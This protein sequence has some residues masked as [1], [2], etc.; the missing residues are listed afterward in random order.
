[1]KLRYDRPARSWNEALPIGNGRLGAMVF[2]GVE[3]EHLQ[4]NEDTLWSGTPKD[5]NNPKAKEMLAEVRKLIVDEK[6]VEADRVCRGMMGPYTQSYLP[7]GDLH[8]QFYH[9]DTFHS[10]ERSLNLQS[11]TVH[12]DY[13]V[14]NVHYTREMFA[15]FPD[16]A[17][18]IR[19]TASKPGFLHFSVNLGS[20]LKFTTAPDQDQFVLSGICP[21][22]VDPSYYHSDDPIQYGDPDKTEAIKFEGRIGV[23]AEDGCMHVDQDGLHVTEAT[24]V[25]LHFS[26]ATSFNGYDK[27]PGL[28][29][30][31]P[32]LAAKAFLERAMA[33]SFEELKHS[34]MEDY[35]SFFNRVE[36][37]LGPSI[38]PE[39]LPTDQ[40]ILDYGAKDPK[41]VELLFQYGR[42]LMI[43]SS[44]PGSQPANLQGIWNR[45]VR[46]PWSSNYTLNIN[47]QMNYWPVE[48]CN[49]SE[50]HEPL[51]N[52]IEELAQNG[53]KTASINYGCSG[54]TAHHNADIWR[55]SGPVGDYGHGDPVWAFWPLGGVWLS[56][57]LWE[58]F[59]FAKNQAYLRETAY[60]IMKEAA[61]FCLDWLID[62]GKG[63]LVTAPSTS[64]EHKFMTTD[65]QLAA[66]SMATTMDMSLIWELFTNCI[67]AAEVL[68]I[69]D[70]FRH[71]L[72]AAR[73][74]LYPMQIGRYGQ[75]QEWIHDFEDEDPH[76]RHVSHLFGVF[77]GRQLTD[78]EGRELFDAARR[79]LER[80][81]DHGTG[82]SLAWKIC[83]WARFK[84]GDRAHRL[85]S[86][87]L[88][89]VN[90][91][92][93]QSQ[94]GGV[95][96]NLFD[97]HP[98]F[99]IDGNFG[100]TAGL[101][102]ML[103]Q[104]H[105]GAIHLLPALPSAWSTGFVKGLRARGGFELNLKWEKNAFESAEIYS[106]LGGPC[107]LEIEPSIEVTIDEQKI[108]V[109]KMSTNRISFDTLAGQRYMLKRT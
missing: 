14:G 57:H 51:L 86:N 70:P 11:G 27:S 103:V 100:F 28:D 87:L 24:T 36:L 34:H 30:K 96:A 46:P 35:Q 44:R 19:L 72:T 7:L 108:P 65:G 22:H 101:A 92:N 2:G 85:I 42:Y 10:Y 97:A 104:S 99:Q 16:Q 88:Q 8:L 62:D 75:L 55:Q 39:N 106:H 52:F 94:K 58:H 91:E 76:H 109:K 95:Y 68:E 107:Q 64:P 21:E 93:C 47:A 4:L 5:T 89:L 45:E 53:K 90:E 102:E 43:A 15:S 17:M 49:L 9:G 54:W 63:N 71:Q 79:S 6:Y 73:E 84:D 23:N 81:G 82:W 33:K 78:S 80:R 29:G 59:T 74:Q 98:P 66:V 1:M 60:P 61:L 13:K 69:D 50:C 25:T 18:A 37:D 38:A 48:T 83:L 56:Q 12:V 67:D 26:A 77:P 3:K 31:D 105:S 41:L 20:S 32:S 40:W